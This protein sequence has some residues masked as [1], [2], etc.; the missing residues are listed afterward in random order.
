MKNKYRIAIVGM[1]HIHASQLFHQFNQYA[2]DR[3]EWAGYADTTDCSEELK[4]LKRRLNF[5]EP[6]MASLKY[7]ENYLDLLDDDIDIA[8]VCTDV[9]SHGSICEETLKR[10]IHTVVEKP[11]S[12]TLADGMRMY[13]A[14]KTYDAVL[15]INWPVAWFDRYNQAKALQDSGAVGRPLR[16]QYRS[17][18]TRGPYKL[19]EYPNEILSKLWWY[20]SGRGGGSVMD[21]AGYGFLLSTWF[22][23]R[24]LP[25]SVSGIRKN[26]FL[27]FSDVEDYSVFTMD[28]GDAVSIVEGSWS[29]MS[30]GE[31]PTGPIVYGTEGV[32]VADRFLTDVKVYKDFKPYVPSPAPTAVYSTDSA[33]SQNI[34]INLIRHLEEGT[35]LHELVTVDFNI[36]AM[37]ALDA[38]IR[39][40]ESGKAETVKKIW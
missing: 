4:Q 18:S 34:S 24:R 40:C 10:G 17:P 25:L 32:L 38:G 26:F 29:T 31:I 15:V 5:Y 37:A 30:N 6:G 33:D 36:I 35:P 23:N 21:Y 19:G 27:P 3:I 39:A 11:M 12:T 1:D 9:A 20:Q 16:F 13:R 22:M 28:Y 8:L 2:G 7:Y 14:A